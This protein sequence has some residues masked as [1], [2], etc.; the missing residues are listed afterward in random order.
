MPSWLVDL[1]LTMLDFFSAF[2]QAQKARSVVYQTMLPFVFTITTQKLNIQSKINDKLDCKMTHFCKNT[3]SAELFYCYPVHMLCGFAYCE[4][5]DGSGCRWVENFR[6]SRRGRCDKRVR[7]WTTLMWTQ[8]S[9]NY[10]RFPM[11]N[12]CFIDTKCWWLFALLNKTPKYYWKRSCCVKPTTKFLSCRPNYRFC[13]R[14]T[15]AEHWK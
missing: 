5:V 11:M 10:R 7:I 1:T 15:T 14:N 6:R 9:S 13:I 8:H 4:T 12:F 3:H 2:K